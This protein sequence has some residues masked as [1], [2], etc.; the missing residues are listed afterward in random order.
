VPVINGLSFALEP[1]KVIGLVGESGAGKSMVGR[2]VAQLLPPGFAVTGG[3]LSFAGTDLV[4][5]GGEARRGL[6]GREIAFIPQ[7]PLSALNPVLT[8]RAQFDEH[9]ARIGVAARDRRDRM[10]AAFDAVH[11]RHGAELLACYPHQLSGGMCQRVLIALAFASQPKLVI[12]DEPTTAL[13]V[14]I[15]ARIV[16]LIAEMQERDNTA[17]VFITHDLRLAAQVCDDILVLYA[18]RTAEYGP[19]RKVFATPGHPYTRCLQ[20]ANPAMRSRR[21]LYALPERMPGLR[22]YRDITGCASRRAVR[23]PSRNA[24]A[25]RRHWPGSA[26]DTLRPASARP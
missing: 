17:V 14:T 9:L 18:G 13:D 8:I 12:A 1:G 3:S 11:L 23:S 4:T 20:L 19:A 26:P 24:I 2:T 10:L 5:M 6:L 16:R 21:A 7:E 25:H 22:A 15:Q